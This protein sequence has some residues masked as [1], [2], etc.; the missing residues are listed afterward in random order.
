MKPKTLPATLTPLEEDDAAS[1][2]EVMQDLPRSRGVTDV[3]SLRRWGTCG[4]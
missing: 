3:R 4:S 1:R 2:S